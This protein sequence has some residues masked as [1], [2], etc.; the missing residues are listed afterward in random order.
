[1]VSQALPGA[2]LVKGFNHL[3]AKLLAADPGVNGGRRVIFLSS[4][5]EAAT[6]SVAE[7]AEL[8]G[9]A[10]IALGKLA[11]GGQLVHGQ[12]RSWGQLIFQDLVKFG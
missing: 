9:F 5:D 6:A 1:M 8:L 10:P 3:P 11:E 7:L 4:D 2:R 12:G